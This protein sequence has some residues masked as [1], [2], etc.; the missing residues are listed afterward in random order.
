MMP[1]LWISRTTAI[2]FVALAYPG[3]WASDQVRRIKRL[4]GWARA[5]LY[6]AMVL[7][8]WSDFGTFFNN[9]RTDQHVNLQNLVVSATLLNGLFPVVD[10]G[11]SS[12]LRSTHLKLCQP[13]QRHYPAIHA[14]IAVPLLYVATSLL[15]LILSAR[16]PYLWP[17]KTN[18]F[19]TPIATIGPAL[20][21]FMAVF[22]LFALALLVIHPSLGL[23]ERYEPLAVHRGDTSRLD[24]DPTQVD[25]LSSNGLL[26]SRFLEQESS[27]GRKIRQHDGTVTQNHV[28]T[29]ACQ[30]TEDGQT[31]VRVS[32]HGD[33]D[34]AS[35][36]AE[37]DFY[38]SLKSWAKLSSME[39]SQISNIRILVVIATLVDTVAGWLY[40]GVTI[41]LPQGPESCPR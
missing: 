2:W 8:N 17:E 19:A 9:P 1:L 10:V 32:Q 5:P 20:V 28:S 30:S 13:W 40:F 7:F 26:A 37:M 24:Q 27:T 34:H 4:S 22:Q 12:L 15:V 21:L 23:P 25:M 11:V 38:D 14:L 6:L 18:G 35:P 41:R 33:A 3:L 31:A 16:F 39:R 29:A 36:V